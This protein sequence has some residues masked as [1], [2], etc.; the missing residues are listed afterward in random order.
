MEQ[1]A[2]GGAFPAP[3]GASDRVEITLTHQGARSNQAELTLMMT[4]KI[5]VPWKLVWMPEIVR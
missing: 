2:T 3:D 1:I 4:V 5:D